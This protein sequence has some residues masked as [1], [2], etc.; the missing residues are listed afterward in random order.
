MLKLTIIYTVSQKW[1][2]FKWLTDHI[3]G[4]I[5]VSSEIHEII[6]DSCNQPWESWCKSM[7][8]LL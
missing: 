4:G 8:I 1:F 5:M 7:Y 6:S 3:T 2:S